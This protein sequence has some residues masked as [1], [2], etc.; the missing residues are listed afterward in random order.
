MGDIDGACMALLLNFRRSCAGPCSAASYWEQE[1]FKLR[2]H[3]EV[4]V[5]SKEAK[6]IR[7]AIQQH[8]ATHVCAGGIKVSYHM[9]RVE[10]SALSPQPTCAQVVEAIRRKKMDAELEGTIMGTGLLLLTGVGVFMILRDVIHL[11]GG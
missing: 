4:R 2:M 8:P 7:R 1:A 10:L 3:I 5:L 11:S 9:V 6:A